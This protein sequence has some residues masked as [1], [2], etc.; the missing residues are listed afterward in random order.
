MIV[1]ILS[2]F[3]CRIIIDYNRFLSPDK[4]NQ[5]N[6]KINKKNDNKLNKSVEDSKYIKSNLINILFKLLYIKVV[7]SFHQIYKYRKY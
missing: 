3:N 5:N 4:I 2:Y 7:L 1:S 6:L